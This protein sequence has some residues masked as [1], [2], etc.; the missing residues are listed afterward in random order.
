MK[1]ADWPISSAQAYGGVLLCRTGQVLLREPANHFDGYVWTF[2][3][4]R[5]DSGETPE[6]TA[7]RE[8]KEETGYTA[9]V[10]DVL[11]GI[12]HSGLSSNAYF[13]MR[14]LG[15]QGSLQWETTSTRWV[16]FEVA[17]DLISKTSNVKGRQR[18][19]AVL[20]TAK[21]WFDTNQISVLSD[22][23]Q[24]FAPPAPKS[25]KHIQ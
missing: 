23:E 14:H 17:A 3:K 4:G 6:E 13:V 24:D 11:P 8:V 18:D 19:L 16:S 5:P 25:D 7:L 22:V 12:F 21:N 15:P 1:N 9:E 10:V 2:A 20:A